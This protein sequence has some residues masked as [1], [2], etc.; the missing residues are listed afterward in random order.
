V[1]GDGRVDRRDAFP[2]V[3]RRQPFLDDVAGQVA[4]L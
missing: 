3:R 2:L 4:T 1:Q